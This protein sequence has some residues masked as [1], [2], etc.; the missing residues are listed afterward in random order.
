MALD[1]KL[2]GSGVPAPVNLVDAFRAGLAA[3]NDMLQN[4]Q[5]QQN[6][7]AT[8]FAN[9]RAPILAQQ[10]DET[11]AQNL[12]LKKAEEQRAINE[13]TLA[14][15][16]A[17]RE[18]YND[19]IGKIG[20]R[21]YPIKSM[22]ELP[23]ALQSLQQEREQGALHPKAFDS[24]ANTIL[25]HAQ[26][27]NPLSLDQ[28]KYVGL[29]ALNLKDQMDR[30]NKIRDDQRAQQQQDMNQKNWQKDFA[31]RQA[32]YAETVRNNKEQ[33]AI[34]RIN[35]NKSDQ[36][37]TK[38]ID[39]SVKEDI[40]S[41]ITQSNLIDKAIGL[42]KDNPKAIGINYSIPM[43]EFYQNLYGADGEKEARQ[44][45]GQISGL[46]IKDISGAAVSASEEGRLKRW[47]P[48]THDPLD[49]AVSKLNNFKNEINLMNKERLNAY[50]AEL[51][52]EKIPAWQ[53][54]YDAQPLSNS[55]PQSNGS[56]PYKKGDVFTDPNSG[57]KF[58]MVGDND[59]DPKSWQEVK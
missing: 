33:N 23:F 17:D 6:I 40:A 19:S 20:A 9:S 51:G 35:A 1:Y 21:L 31:L 55:N 30:E 44:L 14:N 54:I 11:Y 12:A 13:V 43:V 48:S 58:K 45:I 8:Q 15:Q 57:R 16:K 36:L 42:L 24:L 56:G 41:N 4:Q 3:R 46:K 39:R 18:F 5:A 29:S 34:G 28:V 38:S 32:Q 47:I 2:I 10:Q 50:P 27:G 7:L 49:V 25:S 37:K 59:A 53:S 52:Y 26:A 22:E